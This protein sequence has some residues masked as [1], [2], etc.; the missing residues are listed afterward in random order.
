MV[1]VLLGRSVCVVDVLF[2]LDHSLHVP[3][4]VLGSH[5]VPFKV[6]LLLG[7]VDFVHLTLSFVLNLNLCVSIGVL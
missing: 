1:D 5:I 7:N 4:M 2:L 3:F 6:V